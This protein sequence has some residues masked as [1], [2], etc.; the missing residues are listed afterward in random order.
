MKEKFEPK[1]GNIDTPKV[2]DADTPRIPGVSNTPESVTHREAHAEGVV[3]PALE[4]EITVTRNFILEKY[5]IPPEHV[6]IVPLMPSE[7]PQR[8]IRAFSLLTNTENPDLN[9]YAE[10]HIAHAVL[11]NA[12]IDEFGGEIGVSHYEDLFEEKKDVVT[13]KEGW[14]TRKGFLDPFHNGFKEFPAIRRDLV[15][16]LEESRDI[17]GLSEEEIHEIEKGEHDLPNWFL[18]A[19]SS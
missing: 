19:A 18:S 3:G 12:L 1:I 16:Q 15:G 8:N 10:G 13:L 9:F 7:K 11:Y 14:I 2:P 17:N 5:S 4:K 6:F